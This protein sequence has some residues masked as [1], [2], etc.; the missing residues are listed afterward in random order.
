MSDL[1]DKLEAVGQFFEEGV[2]SV[3]VVQAGHHRAQLIDGQS[4][5]LTSQKENSDRIS[6]TLTFHPHNHSVKSIILTTLNDLKTVK[7][8]ALSFRNL[9]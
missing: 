6:F 2:Y 5:L 1:L 9:H 7:R 4:S 8:L 3:S